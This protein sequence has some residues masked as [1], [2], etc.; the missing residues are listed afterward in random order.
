[1]PV[2]K[3]FINSSEDI[4]EFFMDKISCFMEN[5]LEALDTVTNLVTYVHHQ[6]GLVQNLI[7][8]YCNCRCCANKCKKFQIISFI[9]FPCSEKELS[10][11]T[12]F[13]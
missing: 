9:A 2:L 8:H 1:M 7:Y 3:Y 12:K 4:N 5:V 11:E 6:G 10:V 13:K